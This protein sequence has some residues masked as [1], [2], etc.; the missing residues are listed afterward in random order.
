MYTYVSYICIHAF[1][2]SWTSVCSSRAQ[3]NKN[4]NKNNNNTG[5]CFV[6]SRRL[7]GLCVVVRTETVPISIISIHRY[8]TPCLFLR[9]YIYCC[10]NQPSKQQV[11]D[12]P[13]HNTKKVPRKWEIPYSSSALKMLLKWA[14][15]TDRRWRT[16]LA[17]LPKIRYLTIS[18]AYIHIKIYQNHTAVYIPA[19]ATWQSFLL[20]LLIITFRMTT[21]VVYISSPPKCRP[22]SLQTRHM[23][24]SSNPIL[25]LEEKKQRAR[26]RMHEN[27]SKGGS[28]RR[29]T[30]G[31]I[32]TLYRRK[33]CWAQRVR[34][35]PFFLLHRGGRPE[36]KK[37][38]FR[39]FGILRLGGL[40]GW[41]AARLK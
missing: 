6:C 13:Q 18:T 7:A 35:R 9:I 40:A 41:R 32:D 29:I 38:N 26:T 19:S 21:A 25:C 28:R 33:G 36:Q 31:Y 2:R 12:G 24:S 4:N 34:V 1:W 23:Y 15:P 5:V 8:D 10:S 11:K 27:S 16:P 20:L 30:A 17:A 37:R 22:W 39:T 14:K 3:W